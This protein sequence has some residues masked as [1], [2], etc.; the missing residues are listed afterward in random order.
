MPTN[1]TMWK[2]WLIPVNIHSPQ[3]EQNRNRK[4]EQTDDN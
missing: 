4:Y 1:W 3:T 2:K